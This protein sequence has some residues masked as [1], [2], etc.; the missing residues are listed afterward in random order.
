MSQSYLSENNFI[1]REKKI[2][3]FLSF[4][5]MLCSGTIYSYSIFRKVLESFLNIS[6]Y[7]SAVPFKI[8]LLCF[9]LSMPLGG[10]LIEKKGIKKV[11]FLGALALSASWILSSFSKSFETFS[12][13]YGFLG[14]IGVG[15]IYGVPLKIASLLY[16]DRKGLTSG[17]VLAGFG[18][19][20]FI[21]S[22]LLKKLIINFGI[23][24]AFFS[25]GLMFLVIF[26]LI[27]LKIKEI[28]KTEEDL[29][30]K[31][32]DLN[33]IFK[34]IEFYSL[35]IMMASACFVSL[36]SVSFTAG[37]FIDVFSFSGERAAFLVSMFALF[38]TA[39]RPIYGWISDKI[40]I[41]KAILLT[42]V[43]YFLAGAGGLYYGKSYYAALSFFSVLWF[44]L[45]GWLAIAPSA[46]IKLFGLAHYSKIYGIVYT[47]YGLGGFAG[48]AYSSLT[49]YDFFFKASAICA[50]IICALSF[51]VKKEE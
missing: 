50:A 44:T 14:G 49:G 34:K 20:A 13:F 51:T 46:T 45:G 23:S 36:A 28:P 27:G 25:Y 6:S 31:T 42:A 33:D 2:L 32:Y 12:L 38:N 39:G 11:Y 16:P 29:N 15:L 30:S 8:L 41:K 48:I 7:Q 40:G 21:N 22:Y 10:W 24:K 37:Y 3:L 47:S 9:A 1:E 18:L 17:I 19:S 35:Y 26:S 5:I 43:S 4:L